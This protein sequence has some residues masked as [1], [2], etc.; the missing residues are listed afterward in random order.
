M[1]MNEERAE[2]CEN[3]SVE[4]VCFADMILMNKVDL[5]QRDHIDIAKSKI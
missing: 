5:C 4:Q 2:G 1:R 3:E